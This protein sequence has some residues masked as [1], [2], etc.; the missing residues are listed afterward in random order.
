ME[1]LLL[2]GKLLLLNLFIFCGIFKADKNIFITDGKVFNA[3]QSISKLIIPTSNSVKLLKHYPI[4]GSGE[5]MFITVEGTK[6]GKFKGQ[7]NQLKQGDRTEITNFA[8]EVVSP[9]DLASGAS[10]GKRQHKPITITKPIGAATP[11]FFQAITTNEVLKTVVISFYN[12][13]PSEAGPSFEVKLTNANVSGFKQEKFNEHISFT[14]Q[15]IEIESKLG[16]TAAMDD[17]H[18]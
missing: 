7:D 11:Q 18:K 12:E 9:R 8:Y 2:T 5:R 16:K 4:E 1:S 3:P 17:W 13:Y 10:S 6:Q 15:K 14:F